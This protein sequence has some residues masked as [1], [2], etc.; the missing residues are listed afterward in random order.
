MA[1]ILNDEGN[2]VE[3][4]KPT[5]VNS[6]PGQGLKDVKARGDAALAT[7]PKV[8]AEEIEPSALKRAHAAFQGALFEPVHGLVEKAQIA[9]PG[10]DTLKDIASDRADRRAAMAQLEETGAGKFG[11]FVGKAAPL[12]AANTPLGAA[13]AAGTSAFLSGGPDKPTGILNE[14]GASAAKA[15]PEAALTF[16]GMQALKGVGK[17][18][19]AAKG[20]YTPEGAKAMELDSAA[21]RQG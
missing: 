16:G 14:L 13:A 18:F 8:T 4:E 15:V 12:V 1:L 9:F 21:R 19:N 7:I 2:W 10:R 6:P 5:G 17:A 3:S 20:N 11:S